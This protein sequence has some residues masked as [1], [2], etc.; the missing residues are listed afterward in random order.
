MSW[1]RYE[2]SY[3]TARTEPNMAKSADMTYLTN[4]VLIGTDCKLAF[5]CVCVCKSPIPALSPFIKLFDGASASSLVNTILCKENII[6]GLI[7]R[8]QKANTRSQK[9]SYLINAIEVSRWSSNKWGI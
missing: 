8:G 5:W 9:I 6:L 3:N 1:S 2:P 7:L 4:Y